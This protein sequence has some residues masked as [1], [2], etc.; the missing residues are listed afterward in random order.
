MREENP[1]T[2]S[3]SPPPPPPNPGL[4]V[5]KIYLAI[6]AQLFKSGLALAQGWHFNQ[7]LD[8]LGYGLHWVDI[9]VLFN[10]VSLECFNNTL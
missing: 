2:L 5:N 6:R 3:P 9:L 4:F 10:W 8:L 1:I 7:H